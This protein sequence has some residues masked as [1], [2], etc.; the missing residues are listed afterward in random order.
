MHNQ[1]QVRVCQ[2]CGWPLA[3]EWF[4]DARKAVVKRD[5]H[6]SGL[7]HL[8]WEMLSYFRK[9]PGQVIPFERLWDKL[10]FNRDE[11]PCDN[12]LRVHVWNL[13]KD[14]SGTPYRIVT[15]ARQGYVF[16]MESKVQT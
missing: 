2:C 16:D 7:P 10:Y 14:L 15:R 4:D 5:G 1:K 3:G 12:T 9:Y 13:R 6:R 11:P 8:R